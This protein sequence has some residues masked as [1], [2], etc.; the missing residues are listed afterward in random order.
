MTETH[1]EIESVETEP[2]SDED[3]RKALLVSV[4]NGEERMTLTFVGFLSSSLQVR[5]EGKVYLSMHLS[6]T[7][8]GQEPVELF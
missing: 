7:T 6:A 1:F 2:V 3:G 5:S 8:Q 4:R